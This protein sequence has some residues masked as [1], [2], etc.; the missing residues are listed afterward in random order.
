MEEPSPAGLA[1]RNMVV[2]GAGS[3]PRRD[4]VRAP[5]AEA[6]GPRWRRPGKPSLQLRLHLLVRL[7]VPLAEVGGG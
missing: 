5:G 1:V 3:L 7:A 4:A 2:E 6:P